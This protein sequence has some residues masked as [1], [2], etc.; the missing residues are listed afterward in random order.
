[1]STPITK[2]E[3]LKNILVHLNRS[4]E[5]DMPWVYSGTF[6]DTMYVADSKSVLS[7]LIENGLV[8]VRSNPISKYSDVCISTKGREFIE[9]AVLLQVVGLVLDGLEQMDKP[10]EESLC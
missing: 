9:D 2:P 7:D 3:A 1:M 6:D 5:R 4:H 8:D 10:A